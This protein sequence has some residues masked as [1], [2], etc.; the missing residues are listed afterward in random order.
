MSFSV[1]LLKAVN[2]RFPAVE[3]PFNLQNEGKMS[4]SQWQYQWGSKTV[5]CFAP[6]YMP[7]DIFSGKAVLDMGCGA[8]GKSLYYLSI[9][10]EKVV[11]VDIVPH[12]K[13]EA[14]AFAKELGFEDRFTFILGD[15]LNLPIDEN[16]FDVVIMNDFME[17][18]YDPRG[19][20]REA[21][22]VLKP[23]GRIYINFPPYYHPTGIH[24][25]D[26]IGIPWV[27]MLFS[28]K[29]LIAAYKDLVKGLPDEQERLSLRFST[30]DQGREYISYLN[31]MT[32]RKFHG[33]VKE[34]GLNLHWYQEIPLRRYFALFAKV[35]VLKE[36][37]VKMCACVIVKP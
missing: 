10:A 2:K 36:M 16:T 27:H 37:F 8:S 3:H 19:A 34:M 31:K 30:D 1:K 14:E 20:I 15:A 11:G 22:R 21:L 28:E 25:S 26:V 29:T 5:E 24:M 32:I 4:Y 6:R 13:E 17:H 12:Y 9:G 7:E 23:G 33:I 35:P 18:I